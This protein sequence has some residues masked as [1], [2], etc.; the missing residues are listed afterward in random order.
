MK[1]GGWEKEIKKQKASKGER[2]PRSRAKARASV[3]WPGELCPRESVAAPIFQGGMALA[4]IQSRTPGGWGYPWGPWN[5]NRHLH[6]Q[7]SALSSLRAAR[8]MH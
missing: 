4:T 5:T 1:V 6:S 2:P 7:E 3:P 8:H